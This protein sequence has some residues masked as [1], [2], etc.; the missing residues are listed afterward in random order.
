LTIVPE[1]GG[2]I[3]SLIRLESGY[4]YLLQPPEP[5]RAYRPRSFGAKFEDYETSGFD[6]C[7]PAVA[8]C[9]YPEEPFLRSVLPDHGDIWS[10]PANAE[11]HGEIVRLTTTLRSLPLRFTK[12]VQLQ[13]NSVR[14]EYQVTNLNQA[15]VKFLWSAHP[16]LNVT[17]GAEIVLPKN[18]KE[19]E[20][21]WS[22]QGRLGKPGERCTWPE[23]RDLCGRTVQL[24]QIVSPSA[25]TAEKLFTSRLS[26]GFCGM[27]RPREQ[28][29]IAFRFDPLLVPYVGV[30]I[31]QGGWPTSRAAKHF[32]VALEPCLG[33]PD[34]LEDAIS[35]N[36]CATL[37]GHESMRWWMEIEVNNGPPRLPGS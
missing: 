26:E 21:A 14:L 28:E 5:E 9:Q 17:P 3:V 7:V 25:G 4:E 27:F 29:S 36:E 30:W 34:S 20:L 31:C 18:V 37:R 10:L 19:L 12:T 23:T 24:N 6:E 33:R 22:A 13:A 16:L 1:F 32:T 35:R 11:V 15:E 2:K 8:E